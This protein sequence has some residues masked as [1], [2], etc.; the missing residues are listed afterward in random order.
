MPNVASS[1]AAISIYPS[2]KLYL[3]IQKSAKKR[4]VSMSSIIVKLLEPHAGSVDKN[5]AQA[6]REELG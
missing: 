2:R 5:F 6:V 4:D 3:E 1:T